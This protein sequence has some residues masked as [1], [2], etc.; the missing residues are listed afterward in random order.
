MQINPMM[1]EI[2]RQGD[3]AGPLE[4]GVAVSS[5]TLYNYAGA[6]PREFLMQRVGQIL[7]S[8]PWLTS[9]WKGKKLL[10]PKE[11]NEERCAQIINLHFCEISISLEKL[12][13]N[14]LEVI[15]TLKPYLCKND[16]DLK[17]AGPKDVPFRVT[18][19]RDVSQTDR[20]GLLVSINHTLVDGASFYEIYGM[21]SKTTTVVSLDP[22]RLGIKNFAK[23]QEITLGKAESKL[24]TNP[25]LLGNLI[26]A[27]IADIWRG[28]KREVMLCELEPTY[29]EK[30][31]QEFT[32]EEDVP[33]ISNNDIITSLVVRYIHYIHYIHYM[34]YIHYIHYIYT[35]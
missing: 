18:L 33:F 27:I 13:S 20:L 9:V 34:H 12:D 25:M 7:R 17:K 4:G 29:L 16:N 10:Y 21:L 24:F 30:C 22:L 1:V 31:K 28:M 32:P 8:N 26:G 35:T 3:E 23:L 5:L 19:I 14:Y 15:S 6:P 11:I 2:E